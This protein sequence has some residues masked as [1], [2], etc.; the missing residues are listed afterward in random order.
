MHLKDVSTIVK[1]KEN[2][3]QKSIQSRQ[4]TMCL[5][6]ITVISVITLRV[7]F[8]QGIA[9]F[10]TLLLTLACMKA[11]CCVTM[12]YLVLFPY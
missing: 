11:K 3:V 10:N 5:C 9:K 7:H 6:K 2:H 4:Q 8:S 1:S 12:L